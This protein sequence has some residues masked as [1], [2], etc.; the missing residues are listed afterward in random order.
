MKKRGQGKAQVSIEFL[1][2]VGFAF[3]MTVPL[4]II[5]YQQSENIS[6]EV[7]ASQAD[8][9]ASEIRDAADEVYYIGTPSKK[10]ITVFL[11]ENVNGVR[12]SGNT[13]VFDIDSADGDYEIVKWT[14]ANLTGSLMN[15]SGIHHVSAE[16]YYDLSGTYVNISEVNN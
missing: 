16:S 10:T 13:I 12:I 15:Y 1:L 14:V 5:F 4:I 2:I 11:P 9:V 3:L 6:K 7:T 8:K